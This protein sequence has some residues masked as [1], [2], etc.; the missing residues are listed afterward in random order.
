MFVFRRIIILLIVGLGDYVR[1]LC[2]KVPLLLYLKMN[3]PHKIKENL[4]RNAIFSDLTENA[5]FQCTFLERSSLVILLKNKTIFEAR[6][7]LSL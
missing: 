1:I 5:T 6:F 7:Q 3:I 2:T 4:L